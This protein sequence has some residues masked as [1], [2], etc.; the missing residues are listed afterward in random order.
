MISPI[1]PVQQEPAL[2]DLC[3]ELTNSLQAYSASCQ[4]IRQ[5]LVKDFGYE[6]KDANEFINDIV[7]GAYRY[8]QDKS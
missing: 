2:K 3:K 6:V 8:P 4:K 5:H 1:T 7:R